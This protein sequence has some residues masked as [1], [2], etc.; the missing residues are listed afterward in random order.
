MNSPI[1]IIGTY[2]HIPS[3]RPAKRFPRQCFRYQLMISNSSVFHPCTPSLRRPALLPAPHL[4]P[5]CLFP[6]LVSS[7][8]SSH[9]V[10]VPLVSLHISPFR[11]FP[12][13][14]PFRRPVAAIFAPSAVSWGGVWCGAIRRDPLHQLPL[15]NIRRAPS[16]CQVLPV[17]RVAVRGDRRGGRA[18]PMPSTCL[19]DF[20]AVGAIC[21]YSFGEI[22]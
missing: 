4:A 13:S 22:A 20:R 14:L 6:F 18:L 9:P 10:P 21:I 19:C 3:P 11:L 7:G 5:P 8:V 17:H 2:A 12:S 16:A 15:V 1:H